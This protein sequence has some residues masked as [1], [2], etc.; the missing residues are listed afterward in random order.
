LHVRGDTMGKE[1][2]ERRVDHV[3]LMDHLVD[4]KMYNIDE[5]RDMVYEKG[6]PRSKTG[7]KDDD[8]E[9][10]KNVYFEEIKFKR[11]D[12]KTAAS[13]RDFEEKVMQILP[14]KYDK[15]IS[16]ATHSFIK[17]SIT[18]EE[19]FKAFLNIFGPI[20]VYKYIYLYYRT[21]KNEKLA[22]DLYNCLLREISKLKFRHKCILREVK[23]WKDFFHKVSDEIEANIVDRI[24]NNKLDIAKHYR[25]ST[26]RMFQL[27]GSIK[28]LTLKELSKFKY[29]NNFLQNPDAKSTLQRFMFVPADKAQSMLHKI[30]NM[31][32]LVMFIYFNLS[33]TK[34]EF[35]LGA[36]DN[37]KINPNLLKVFM[38]HYVNFAKKKNYDIVTDEEDFKETEGVSNVEHTKPTSNAPTKVNKPQTSQYYKAPLE[39]KRQVFAEE[40]TNNIGVNF[41][42]PELPDV[43]NEPL[44]PKANTDKKLVTSTAKGWGGDST[45]LYTNEA[46]KRKAMQEEFPEL[47][48]E[49]NSSNLLN[50]MQQNKKQES[51]WG[52]AS[53]LVKPSYPQAK[54]NTKPSQVGNEEFP[55]LNTNDNGNDLFARMK[56]S[57]PSNP[58][59]TIVKAKVPQQKTQQNQPQKQRRQPTYNDYN[60]EEEEDYE[61]PPAKPEPPAPKV[62]V[63]QKKFKASEFPE[64][65]TAEKEEEVDLFRKMQQPKRNVVNELSNKFGYNESDKINVPTG[66]RNIIDELQRTTSG[67]S[68]VVI[69]KKKKKK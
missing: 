63:H 40:L 55:N 27:F 36:Y 16:K 58:I 35:S 47:K 54:V 59:V 45:L 24:E 34:F 6:N 20:L 1:N 32:I 39:P 62:P 42:F 21:L 9:Q 69:M 30:S 4:E 50:K 18:P 51:G 3:E 46:S 25:I 11:D 2:Y 13:F 29:L 49:D 56:S 61:E 43:K 44:K 17:F 33:V 60:D 14:A 38:K 67:N 7:K 57:K 22:N 31:D 66:E 48:T 12:K 37:K 23:T 28:T 68:T 41:E 8:Y 53:N 10:D 65:R 5:E 19:L 26:T 52:A 15:D 64:M